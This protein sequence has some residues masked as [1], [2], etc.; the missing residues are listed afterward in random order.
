MQDKPKNV[1]QSEAAK[2]GWLKQDRRRRITR[3]PEIPDTGGV[4]GLSHPDDPKVIRY[5]AVGKDMRERFYNLVS[6]AKHHHNL[7]IVFEDW[8]RKILDTKR[9]PLYVEIELLSDMSNKI[10]RVKYWTKHFSQF[11]ELLNGVRF[12]T[13]SRRRKYDT[14][15]AEGL[16]PHMRTNVRH[17]KYE[18]DEQFAARKEHWLKTGEAIYLSQS[19]VYRESRRQATLD[20]RKMRHDYSVMK[21]EAKREKDAKIVQ[22]NRYFRAERSKHKNDAQYMKAVVIEQN[23]RIEEAEDELLQRIQALTRELKSKWK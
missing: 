15:R 3:H 16:T 4:F 2:K 5:V 20:N 18:T 14:L 11:A 1:I 12:D 22:A 7:N 6:S 10:E 9:E 17:G 23:R 13:T 19:L 8:C 21:A